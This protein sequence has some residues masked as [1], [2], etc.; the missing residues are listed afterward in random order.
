MENHTKNGKNNK[1]DNTTGFKPKGHSIV[2]RILIWSKLIYKL[3][4]IIFRLN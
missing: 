2:S 1:H 4:Y 3:I